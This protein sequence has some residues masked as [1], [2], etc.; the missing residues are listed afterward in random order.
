MSFDL[1]IKGAL[2]YTGEGPA[3]RADVGVADGPISAV[4]PALPTQTA[5][6]VLD[7]AGLMLCPGFIDLH[8]RRCIDRCAAR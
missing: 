6:E 3:L 1:L 7:A 5:A 2:V 8:A 4:E